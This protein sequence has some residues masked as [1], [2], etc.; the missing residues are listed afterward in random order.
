MTA[1]HLQNL[2]KQ[3]IPED[4][5]MATIHYAKPLDMIFKDEREVLIDIFMMLNNIDT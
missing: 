3:N 1:D 4:R 2:D 5:D